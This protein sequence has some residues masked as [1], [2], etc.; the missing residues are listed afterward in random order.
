MKLSRLDKK[1]LQFIK[2]TYP[3]PW[4]P[5]ERDAIIAF[6]ERPLAT[7]DD[8]SSHF[9]LQAVSLPDLEH[10]LAKL[11]GY[12]YVVKVYLAAPDDFREA[13]LAPGRVIRMSVTRPSGS[14]PERYGYQISY[15]GKEYLDSLPPQK[16]KTLGWKLIEKSA[17]SWVPPIMWFLLG[18]LISSLFGLDI[19]KLV[20]KP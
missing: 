9:I 10:I 3:V 16:L 17:E 5:A 15:F 2:T 12:Q 6:G 20:N 8:I 4:S 19:R 13:R 11:I 1:V 18:L 7:L 14:A